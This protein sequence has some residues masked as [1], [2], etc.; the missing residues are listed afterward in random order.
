MVFSFGIHLFLKEGGMLSFIIPNKWLD[1]KY[2]E[3]IKSF[4]LTHYKIISIIGFDK[5]IFP[6]A[7]V[8]TIIL[9]NQKE[10]DVSKRNNHV[11]R[12]LNIFSESGREQLEQLVYSPISKQLEKKLLTESYIFENP[13]DDIQCTFVNQ[14]SLILKEKWSFKYLYQSEFERLLSQKP[15]IL[16]QNNDVTNVNWEIR[17]RCK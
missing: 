13:E 3:E 7:Q 1:V 2:G 10:S 16:M 17:T 9:L 14:K 8:S 12:F 11:T 15:C 6:D 4:L 5:N